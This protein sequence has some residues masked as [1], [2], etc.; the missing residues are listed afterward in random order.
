MVMTQSDDGGRTWTP[1]VDTEFPNPNSAID[2]IRLRNGHLV[3]IYNDSFRG[4]RMPLTMRVSMDDGKTWPSVR[5]IVN[6][7]GDDAAYPFII[8]TADGKIRGVYT[9]LE[10]T[11][12]NH[13]VL[14]EQ[15]ILSGA[16]KH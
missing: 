8:E 5:N 12:I 15:D 13:F 9:S 6:I 16:E 4:E 1:G 2:L 11:V 7:P 14:D 10:R 3:L